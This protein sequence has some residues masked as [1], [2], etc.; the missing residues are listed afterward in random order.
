MS[1]QY[2]LIDIRELDGEALINSARVGDNILSLLAR[3]PDRED[4]IR[5][6]LAGIAEGREVD[7]ETALEAL[8]VIAGLRH[9]EETVE[10]EIK[11]MPVLN[12]ILENKVLGR[13]YK[14]GIEEGVQ[15]GVR[16]GVQQ[17][18]LTLLRR[19]IE[20]RF[21]IL[22]EWADARLSRSSS[23]EIEAFSLRLLDATSLEELLK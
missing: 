2:R 8:L 3:L 5:R 21:G 15:Q 14:R 18:E 10:Q 1:F 16:Q 23:S 9:L 17:G 19:M 4:A 11:K 12:D 22:P 20:G 6:V 13:E 7:R